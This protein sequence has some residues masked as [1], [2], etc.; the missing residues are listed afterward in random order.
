[1]TALSFPKYPVILGV[2]LAVILL[3]IGLGAMLALAVTPISQ[4]IDS[5]FSSLDGDRVFYSIKSATIQASLSVFFSILIA[6][7][8]SIA[9]SRRQ[10]WQGMPLLIMIISL[11]MVLPTTVAA[12][13]LLAVWGRNGL[14]AMA[15]AG[16]CDV[17]LYGLH[18]V[19]IAHMMLNVPLAMRVMMPLLQAVPDAKWRLSAHLGMTAFDRFRHIEWPCLR[20]AIPGLASLIFLLCFTSFSLVLMLGGGPKVTTLEVEIYSA[21]RFDFN[22]T[23]AASLGL[24]QFVITALVVAGLAGFGGGHS[25]PLSLSSF[26]SSSLARVD[27]T[28]FDCWFDLLLIAVS[29]GLMALPVLMIALRGINFELLTLLNRPQFLDALKA[30]TSIALVSASLVTVL[31]LLMATAK[32]GLTLPY[33]LGKGRLA[34]FARVIMDQG[35][36][37]YLVI[38]S[39]VLGTA[40]FILLRARGDVFGY[41][42]GVVVMANTLLALPFAYR[43]LERRMITVLKRHD[44]LALQLGI[45]GFTRLKVLTL[46]AL[47]QDIGLVAGLSA[48]LSLG[49][50]GVIA[51]FANADFRTLPWLLY[52]LSGKYA[53]AEAN[54]L[55]LV[56]LLLTV[57]L[58]MVTRRVMQRLLGG[59]YA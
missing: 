57:A 25:S 39:V 26:R 35:V 8:A 58:F 55:A 22:L 23:T 14:F 53:A 9:V 33:R 52:Q 20:G 45:N 50:L 29:I 47:S 6:V 28:R 41:T 27:L 44:R 5:F 3:M 37:L 11:A 54:A 51:L 59:R 36:M 19:V 31:S 21:I 15:C 13:G 32:A 40:A 49:D 46:P 18:G 1:M 34:P 2:V 42:F 10:H 24:I 48:A 43:L 38:P 56:L 12:M 17:N 16:F 7:P 4:G 30:S